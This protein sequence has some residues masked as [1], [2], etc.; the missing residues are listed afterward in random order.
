[1]IPSNEVELLL[2]G[3]KEAGSTVKG[4]LLTEDK[5]TLAI[6]EGTISDLDSARVTI[7][8]AGNYMRVDFTGAEFEYGDSREFGPGHENIYSDLVRAN[9]PC[10]LY[11]AIAVLKEKH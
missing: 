9:L 7:K 11:F 3:W 5:M 4:L 8:N 2:S 6:V 10:R 1:M